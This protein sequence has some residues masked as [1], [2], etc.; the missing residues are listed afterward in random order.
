M[1]ASAMP[2]RSVV[3][4]SVARLPLSKKPEGEPDGA[5]K[6]TYASGTGRPCASVTRAT[7]GTAKRVPAGAT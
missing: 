6:L 4:R 1:P 5:V 3:T 2:S 7:S